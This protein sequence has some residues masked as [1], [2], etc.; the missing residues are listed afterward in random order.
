MKKPTK[1]LSNAESQQSDSEDELLTHEV[2]R[3]LIF[4]MLP[5]IYTHNMLTV[6]NFD[7]LDFFN[8]QFIIGLDN[9]DST[10]KWI[11]DYNE[12]TK[13]TMVF[14]LNAVIVLV[15]NAY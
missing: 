6:V 11:T 2:A 3:P 7:H 14:Y 13:E 9:E 8:C 1:Q 10:R 12:K 4:G 5:N 15:E